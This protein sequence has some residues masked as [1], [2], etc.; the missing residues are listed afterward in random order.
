MGECCPEDEKRDEREHEHRDARAEPHAAKRRITG[1]G[2]EEESE[3]RHA[4]EEPG[5]DRDDARVE[6]HEG[7]ESSAR[8]GV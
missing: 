1:E 6:L 8:P 2:D 4:E 3:A 5:H 7:R